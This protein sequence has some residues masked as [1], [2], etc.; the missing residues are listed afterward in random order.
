MHLTGSPL[1]R[2]QGSKSDSCSSPPD[3][4]G[5]FSV[6]LRPGEQLPGIPSHDSLSLQRYTA[7]PTRLVAVSQSRSDD[8][9]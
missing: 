4:S 2:C 6:I 8:G 9:M 5:G 1:L 7:H 3:T